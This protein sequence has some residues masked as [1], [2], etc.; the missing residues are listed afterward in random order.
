MTDIEPRPTSADIQTT[1]GKFDT[2]LAVVEK[3]ARALERECC[4]IEGKDAC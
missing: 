2:A 1:I 3:E 4:E